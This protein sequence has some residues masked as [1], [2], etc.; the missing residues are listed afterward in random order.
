MRPVVQ[1]ITNIVT[2]NDCANALLAAGASPTMAHHPQEMEDFAQVTDA[3]VCNL[4]AS[5]SYEA[6]LRAAALTAEKGHPVVIDPVGCASSFFRRKICMELIDAVRSS[7]PAPGSC[8][9][10][11][12]G[13]A[14][15]I[16]ALA[17]HRNT[18]RGVDETP[19]VTPAAPGKGAVSE[20]PETLE[21]PETS[22]L[23]EALELTKT[24]EL[25][26]T[27]DIS[28]SSGSS[29]SPK[30]LLKSMP[31]ERLALQ[32]GAIVI[33]SGA[34]DYVT[35]GIRSYAVQGG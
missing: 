34:T 28:D 9:L 32:T 3:L 18:G 26:E 35:D 29:E 15:E 12:R 13:N 27:S 30:T 8:C 17:E 2:V 14:S 16:R 6:M 21:L 22:E 19:S 4:G 24:S 5:E 11:I 1:C 23:P 20:L 25:P 7:E 10:C 31:G 33:T